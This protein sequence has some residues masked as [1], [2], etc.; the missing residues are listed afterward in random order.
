MAT[1][2][3][4]IYMVLDVMKEHS[5]DAYYTEEHILFLANK[6]RA[7]L[8]ERKYKNNRNT[9][10]NEV[11]SENEQT[12]CMGL[13]PADMINGLCAGRWL[14][15]TVKIPDTLSISEP[16]LI[17]I[18][19]M[20]AT[21]LTFIAPERMPYVGYNRWLKNIIYASKSADDYL[22]L[23]SNNPQFMFLT[24]AQMSGIFSDPEAAAKLSC[25]T[26]EAGNCD[27]LTMTFP[28]EAALVPSCIEL[29]VQELLGSRYAP[30]DKKN[31]A[32]DGLGEVAVTSSKAARPVESSGGAS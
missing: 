1:F 30:E 9:T 13:E 17:T 7:L 25:D 31:D 2:G 22:Y 10:F 32:K 12:I 8:L 14:K 23:T 19:D 28:L 29:V 20:I 27:I 3:E 18:S 15:S 4:I 6:M 16:K 11:S 21:N 5:D 26:D 24:G